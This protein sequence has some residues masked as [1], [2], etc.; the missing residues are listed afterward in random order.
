MAEMKS[1]ER[2]ARMFE[3]REA[4]RVPIMDFPWQGTVKRWHREGM[5]EGVSYVDYFGLDKIARIRVDN[6]PR[7][8][9]KVLEETDRYRIITTKWGVTL[10]EFKEDDSTPEFIDFT[11]TDKDKWREAKERMTPSKDRVNWAYLKDNYSKWREEGYWI[12]G[13][14]WFGFDVTHSWTVGTE[15]LL[16]AMLEE[17]EWCSDMF[18]YYLDVNIALMD[19]VWDEGYTFDCIWW[20]DDMGFKNS[21]FFSPDTYRKLLKPAHRRAVEW[22][23]NKGIR[24]QLHSCGDI[25]PFI[26]EFIDIGLDALNPL[27]VKA[28]MDPVHLKARY[29]K[30]LVLHGGINAVLWDDREAIINEINRVVPI[31]KESGGYIFASDHSIPNTVS[32]EDFRTIVDLVKK[33][34]SY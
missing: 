28:G 16:I 22:A 14:F 7:F 25:N 8:E 26:P 21:Q 32:L 20:W 33:V 13:D 12:I 4:D 23:H 2:F 1:R 18:N 24:A 27:E 5:P 3:H 11:I 10:R 31:L 30:N 9:V 15:R 34:G 6:S 29:G 19:M 17:P